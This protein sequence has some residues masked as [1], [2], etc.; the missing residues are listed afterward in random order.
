MEKDKSF[1]NYW[2]DEYWRKNLEK[3]KGKR[4]DFLEDIW[5]DIS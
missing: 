1:K 2:N 5:L 3:N 4:L